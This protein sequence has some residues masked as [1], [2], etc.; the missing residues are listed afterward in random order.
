VE[1]PVRASCFHDRNNRSMEQ[2]SA[3][4]A[5]ERDDTTWHPALPTIQQMDM[6]LKEVV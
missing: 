3:D 4:L 1:N 2:L 6:A 5:K